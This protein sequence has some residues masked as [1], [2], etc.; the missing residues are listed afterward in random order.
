MEGKE[1][2]EKKKEKKTKKKINLELINYFYML[3]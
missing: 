2:I 3:V 1:N